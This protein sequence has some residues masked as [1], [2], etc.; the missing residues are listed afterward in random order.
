MNPEADMQLT[1]PRLSLALLALP[2]LV[3][4]TLTIGLSATVWS[5]PPRPRPTPA[6]RKKP[7]PK[8][9]PVKPEAATEPAP[10]AP[11]EPVLQRSNR[12]E[13]DARVVRGETARSGAVYLFQRAPRR[14]PPLVGLQQSYLDEIVVPVLGQDA[15]R[16]PSAASEIPIDPK[17]TPAA[18]PTPGPKPA[19]GGGR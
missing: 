4:A 19:P 15:L 5:A 17:P 6:E 10:D 3:I 1:K 8:P 12:M 13:L 7:A 2:A 14:L 9:A 11:G 18:P 16:A